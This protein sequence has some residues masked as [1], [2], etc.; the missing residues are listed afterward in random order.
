M[1]RRLCLWGGGVMVSLYVGKG[2]GE[3]PMSATP[4]VNFRGWVRIRVAIVPDEGGSSKML[5]GI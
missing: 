1:S 5:S 4:A 2:K 3:V